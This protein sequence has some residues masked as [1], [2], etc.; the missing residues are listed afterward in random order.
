MYKVCLD[1]G[2]GSN[3]PGKRSPDGTFLE[4]EFNKDIVDKVTKLLSAYP[5][6]V[7]VNS[8]GKDLIDTSLNQRCQK[9]NKEKCNIFVSIHANAVGNGWSDAVTGWEAWVYSNADVS[10]KLAKYMNAA[11]STMFPEIKNRGIKVKNDYYVLNSTSMPAIIIEHGFYTSHKEMAMLK[12]EGY[13][14]KAATACANAILKYFNIAPVTNG[15]PVP[16]KEDKPTTPQR[17]C[18]AWKTAGEK[19][20]LDKGII[21]SEHDPLEPI[22][23]GSFGIMMKNLF[24]KY[25]I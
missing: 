24:E 15:I 16:A 19:F 14:N 20:L 11:Y 6:I 17:T 5:S 21:T 9:A 12:T 3:T 2:H 1:P 22:D 10:G 8:K 7:V 23:I 25:N 4:W 13:Q 18:P